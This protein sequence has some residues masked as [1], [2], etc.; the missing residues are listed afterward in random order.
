MP[1]SWQ[2]I[3]VGPFTGGMNTQA[4]SSYIADNELVDCVNLELDLNGSLITRPPIKIVTGPGGTSRIRPIGQAVIGS[5]YYV[6]VANDVTVWA[7]DGTTFTQ[8]VTGIFATKA[9][10]YKSNVYII[11]SSFSAITGGRW[12]GSTYTSI[13]A[14]PRGTDALIYK[15]RMYIADGAQASRLKFSNIADPNVWTASDFFDVSPGDGQT[16]WYLAIFNN[17]LLIFKQDSTYALSYDTKPADATINKISN[18]IGTTGWNCLAQTQNFIFV[19]HEGNVYQ[20]V[21]FEF[22]QINTRVKFELDTTSPGTRLDTV[23]M[24]FV[25]DRLLVRFFNRV[26][27]YNVLTQAWSRWESD[28]SN[29]NNFATF[30]RFPSNAFT[31]TEEK[32]YGGSSISGNTTFFQVKDKHTLTDAETPTIKCSILTKDYV[33]DLQWKFKRLFF[34]GAD[35]MTN[36][37]VSGIATPIVFG[38]TPTWG[39]IKNQTWD[40]LNTWET[41]LT[42]SI[43]VTTEVEAGAGTLKRFIKFNK[44]MRFRQINFQLNLETD[45]TITE[46]PTRVYTLSLFMKAA[47]TVVKQVS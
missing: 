33:S 32:Y 16:L 1:P 19:Y 14:L 25:G 39:D 13:A 36:R 18:E 27:M 9:V 24:S 29:I 38:F 15:E 46:G 17:N 10:Q 5:N 45:G 21:N 34:W 40:S 42:K 26:Y 6:I 12:D 43:E 7:Y 44:G 28:D 11:A 31:D 35:V 20:L 22:I 30:M 41:P 47:E 37:D 3:T 8:I 2:A 4:D 23:A